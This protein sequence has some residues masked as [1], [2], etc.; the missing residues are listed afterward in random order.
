MKLVIIES[1][2]GSKDALNQAANVAYARKCLRHSLLCGESPIASHLLH[3]QHGVLNDEDESERRIGIEAGLAWYA[4]A[5]LCVVFADRGISPGM[6]E[7]MNTASRNGVK[8]EMRYIL[9]RS[10]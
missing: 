2:F 8:C 6:V 4:K 9:K 10:L 1:P 7:G 3:T 5:D